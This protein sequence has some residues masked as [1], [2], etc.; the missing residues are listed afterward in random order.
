MRSAI[1]IVCDSLSIAHGPPMK[2]SGNPEPMRTG[3]PAHAMWHWEQSDLWDGGFVEDGQW[4][5][6]WWAVTEPDIYYNANLVLA[7]ATLL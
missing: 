4:N 5:E 6:G 2:T 1:K 7:A 3:L